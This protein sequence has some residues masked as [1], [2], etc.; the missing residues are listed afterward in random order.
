LSDDQR[1]RA[2]LL[3]SVF[4][5]LTRAENSVFPAELSV[6]FWDESESEV[7]HL[8][9]DDVR[10]QRKVL[11]VHPLEIQPPEAGKSFLIPPQ[12]LSYRSVINSEGGTAS[13]YANLK[14]QWLPQESASKALLEFQIPKACL[15]F[16]ADSGELQLLIRA[17]SRFVTIRSGDRDNLQSIAELTSP[18]GMQKISIPGDLIQATGR[19]GRVFLQIEVS[20]LDSEM[21]SQDMTGEQ[22][23]S[24]RIERVLLSLKGQRKPD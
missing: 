17:G 8:Q 20:E 9:G 19:E 10:R 24:W 7:L 12:L 14:R 6:V 21:Q 15:P 23:D 18:L 2:A 11:V 4:G 1:Y 13:C 22:D 16:A 5:N 3:N